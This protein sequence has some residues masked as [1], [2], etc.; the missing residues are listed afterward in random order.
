M[1]P[2]TE[3]LHQSYRNLYNWASLEYKV[4]PYP[5]RTTIV[6]AREEPL[7]GVWKRKV[8]RE[9]QIELYFTPGS[10]MTCRTEHLGELAERLARCIHEVQSEYRSGQTVQEPFVSRPTIQRI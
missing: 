10:H 9:P 2:P 6:W 1:F 4:G 8:D 5:G 7:K 3:T